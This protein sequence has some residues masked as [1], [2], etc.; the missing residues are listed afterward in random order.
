MDV[1]PYAVLETVCILWTRTKCAYERVCM[2]EYCIYST[3]YLH[4]L[5]WLLL[6]PSQ[7]RENCISEFKWLLLMEE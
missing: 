2:S 7:K 4:F 3:S 1:H 5:T 6:L